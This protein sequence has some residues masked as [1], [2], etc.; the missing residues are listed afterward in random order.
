MSTRCTRAKNATAHP[1]AVVLASQGKRRT[2]AQ[3]Q[4]NDNRAAEEKAATEKAE[5]ECVV[6][7]AKMV[8]ELRAKG[9]DAASPGV[10]GQTS[11]A[12]GTSSSPNSRSINTVIEQGSKDQMPSNV[13][14]AA[15][16]AKPKRVPKV[17]L[18]AMISEASKT[19][20][21]STAGPL[22]GLDKEPNLS[23]YQ[24]KKKSLSGTVKGWATNVHEKTLLK[25]SANTTPNPSASGHNVPSSQSMKVVQSDL[26]SDIG[27]HE[28]VGSQ[29]PPWWPSESTPNSDVEFE[30]SQIPSGWSPQAR[31]P[32]AGKRK[33]E[34]IVLDD[35]PEGDETA[36]SSMQVD[37]DTT[38]E[39]RTTTLASPFTSHQTSVS[40][41][42][43]GD[44]QLVT[45]K[46]KTEPGKETQVKT[47]A[48]MTPV[49]ATETKKSR[50]DYKNSDLPIPA[51]LKW[52]NAF[53]D[54]VILWAGGQSNIWSIPDKT[55]AAALQEIFIAVYPDVEYEV[56]IHSA[57][58]G[59]AWQ[60]L[61]EW[62]SGFGST[63]LV[64]IIH[65]FWEILKGNPDSKE[66]NT[67]IRDLAG[68]FISPPYF[69]FT[70][71][72]CDELDPARNFRSDFILKLISTA[73]LSKTISAAN[74]QSLET[75][76]LK[77]G[78]G[79]EC[80]VAL[81]AAAANFSYSA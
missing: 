45:K 62:R 48:T 67:T 76:K 49:D 56:T 22:H 1:G 10:L 69:P 35:E 15:T 32:L 41:T 30:A 11:G 29:I 52:M 77:K 18:K 61:L 17:S 9:Q 24:L 74:V 7:I 20:T 37:T 5:Q 4:A 33:I 8:M 51:D 34:E 27:T 59:V 31:V 57:V 2:K 53:M 28:D 54:T 73:H 70:H 16:S 21:D 46:A 60:R 14:V 6:T 63:A 43:M 39:I 66:S 75:A 44:T 58:F 50:S 42:A 3:K 12:N 47:S 78:Y 38:H 80:V 81:A 25:G 19:I 23:Q 13:Q 36:E 55:L 64:M 68:H 71:E 40:V 72:D 79:M 65:F 26:Y